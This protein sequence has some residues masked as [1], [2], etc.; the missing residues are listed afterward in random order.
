MTACMR[1]PIADFLG[2]GNVRIVRDLKGEFPA[3]DAGPAPQ[4]DREMTEIARQIYPVVV[5]CR[6]NESHDIG[7]VIAQSVDVLCFKDS[8]TYSAS[9]NHDI[10]SE[11][12]YSLFV[13]CMAR[14]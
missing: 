14:Q 13:T 7:I 10:S 1:R 3:T 4:L 12:I 9:L 5:L 2:V 8:V 6:D 11:T